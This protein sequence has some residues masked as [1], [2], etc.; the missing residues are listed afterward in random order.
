MT[1]KG[2]DVNKKACRRSALLAAIQK[3]QTKIVKVLLRSRSIR[4][5]DDD[6]EEIPIFA[7]CERGYDEIA[8]MLLNRCDLRI[9]KMQC[10]Q[11]IRRANKYL[12]KNIVNE[13]RERAEYD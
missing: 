7:A 13:I 9:S 6:G 10:E 5:N 4:I 2:I 8:E 11:L 12:S 3:G 1:I